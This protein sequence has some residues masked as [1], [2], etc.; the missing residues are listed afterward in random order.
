MTQLIYPFKDSVTVDPLQVSGNVHSVDSFGTVDGPGTRYVVFLQGCLF[1]CKYCH[2]RD[3]W[4][5]EGGQKKAAGDLVKEIVAYKPF[6]EASN[7]GVTVTGGE[8][9]L[10]VPFVKA[11]FI[12]L[13]KE[14]IHTCLDTNGYATKYNQELDELLA[15]TDL[16][17]LDLKQVDDKRH[18]ALTG[19]SN[20]K[21]LKFAQYVAEKGIPAWIRLVVVP[22]YTDDEQTARQ[23]AEFIQP[24]S[25][26]EKVELLPYHE[27]G[28]HKWEAFG[29]RYPLVGVE[30]PPKET[31]LKLQAIF[32]EYHIKVTF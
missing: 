13:K 6:M 11:L 23:M 19:V 31:L 22:G 29:D 2:N 30:P 10:Q 7:G 20:K 27:L 16:V 25:N 21:T 5:L 28:K 3:T 26:V 8:P 1:R 17:L 12:A 15:H 9:L 24:M 18:K 4:D 32:S 14:K